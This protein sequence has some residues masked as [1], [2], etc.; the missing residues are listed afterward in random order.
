[1]VQCE[2]LFFQTIPISALEERGSTVS[3]MQGALPPPPMRYKLV[4]ET[5]VLRKRLSHVVDLRD[6]WSHPVVPHDDI[7]DS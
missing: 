5:A 3:D 6:P 2:Q 4:L 1:M 7:R